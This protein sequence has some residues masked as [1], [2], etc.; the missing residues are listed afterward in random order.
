MKR[1]GI[2]STVIVVAAVLMFACVYTNASDV[3]EL[4][5]NPKFVAID[6]NGDPYSGG[7]LYTY[8][9]GTTTPKTTWTSSTK[10]TANTNP[11]ILDSAGRADVWIDSS[12]S[13]YRFKLLDSDDNVI[14]T[15]DG[16]SEIRQLTT[17]AT[18]LIGH[19]SDGSHRAYKLMSSFDTLTEAQADVGNDYIL[20]IDEDVSLAQNVTFTTSQEIMFTPGSVITLGA[21][22]LV[23]YQN[24]DWG[25]SQIFDCSGGGVVSGP[26]WVNVA[27][28]GADPAGDALGEFQSAID[29]IASGSS[30]GVVYIPKTSSYYSASGTLDVETSMIIKSEGAKIV[31]VT[32]NIKNSSAST[33]ISGVIID[34]LELDGDDAEAIGIHL[35]S[36]T[37]CTITNVYAYDYTDQGILIDDANGVGSNFNT[38]D[39]YKWDAMVDA[40]SSSA[41]G[42]KLSGENND[43]Q[44]SNNHLGSIHGYYDDGNL[45]TFEGGCSDNVINMIWGSPESG[46]TGYAIDLQDGGTYYPNQNIF[47]HVQGKVHAEANTYANQIVSMDSSGSSVELDSGAE[48]AYSVT[49]SDSKIYQTHTYKMVDTIRVSTIEIVPITAVR[50]VTN[51]TWPCIEFSDGDT[52]YASFVI[53]A[54]RGWGNGDITQITLYYTGDDNASSESVVVTPDFR[55]VADGESV[56]TSMSSTTY[57]IA[58]DDTAGKM[59]VVDVD[60]A[61]S[62]YTEGDAVFGYI[63]RSGADGSDSFTGTWELLAIGITFVG[64]G[65]AAGS[66]DVP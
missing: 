46:G 25:N 13:A 61:D 21:H 16:V 10:G 18:W 36:A 40:S 62:E 48:M 26:K 8:E 64:D 60:I 28:Y 45:V 29:T 51:T 23:I 5:P 43:L 20:V 19:E 57:T 35:S 34:N 4:A 50:Y 30:G 11:V 44:I 55:G 41:D 58:M 37:G 66:Y 7:K 31:G 65:P 39:N 38:V 6:A 3:A 32:F 33:V 56:P 63:M 9:T 12:S 59:K 47:G 22:D 14:W 54:P 17:D 27:W 53:P 52:D 42:I 49:H 24:L 15:V 1:Y 2:L